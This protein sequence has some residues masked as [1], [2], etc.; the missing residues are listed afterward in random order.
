MQAATPITGRQE[1]PTQVSSDP[2]KRDKDD[3]AEIAR[4]Q[5]ELQEMVRESILQKADE[6]KDDEKDID[7]SSDSEIDIGTAERLLKPFGSWIFTVT[8]NPRF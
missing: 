2:K 4:L 3:D 5:Q 6:E 1:K 7:S 8:P